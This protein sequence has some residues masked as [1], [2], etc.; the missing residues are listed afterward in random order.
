MRAAKHD[1]GEACCSRL[2]LCGFSLNPGDKHPDRIQPEYANLAYALILTDTEVIVGEVIIRI[3]N[4]F[5]SLFLLR[6]QPNQV[7]Y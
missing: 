7:R 3:F 6:P 2:S 4:R 1:I 5:I